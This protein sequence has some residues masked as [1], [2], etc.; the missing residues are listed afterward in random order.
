MRSLM[1]CFALL[2]LAC[3]VAL[4][5]EMLFYRLAYPIDGDF[6]S[7]LFA[8]LSS[9][10][11]DVNGDGTP[12]IVL[13][14]IAAPVHVPSSV[15]LLGVHA[16][17]ADFL[18]RVDDPGGNNLL[19]YSVAGLGDEDA[20][21]VPGLARGAHFGEYVLWLSGADRAVGGHYT[22]HPAVIHRETGGNDSHYFGTQVEGLGRRPHDLFLEDKSQ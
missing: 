20:D 10:V 14:A 8:G 2:V 15:F 7:Q 4:A 11:E 5:G 1:F 16:R 21:G 9:A 17:H 18:V 22:S 12:D 6:P 3:G 19:G 13:G